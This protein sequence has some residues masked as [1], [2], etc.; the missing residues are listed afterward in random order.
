MLVY[1]RAY[2]CERHAQAA[3]DTRGRAPEAVSKAMVE[4]VQAARIEE[5]ERWSVI[6]RRATKLTRFVIG[7]RGCVCNAPG[8]RCG[9]NLMLADVA[10]IEEQLP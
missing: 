6:L 2:A 4:Q 9:T 10:K 1:R 3:E 5:R 8:H 7:N